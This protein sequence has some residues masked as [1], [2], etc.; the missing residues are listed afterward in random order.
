MTCKLLPV[1]NSAILDIYI[2]QCIIKNRPALKIGQRKK[3][4]SA[5]VSQEE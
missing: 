3:T 1:S 2:M 4:A 5:G